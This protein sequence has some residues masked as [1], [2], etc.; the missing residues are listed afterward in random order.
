MTTTSSFRATVRAAG[1][2]LP[3]LVIGIRSRT[4]SGYLCRTQCDATSTDCLPW[5]RQDAFTGR[6]AYQPEQ[7]LWCRRSIA[8]GWLEGFL[9]AE[10]LAEGILDSTLGQGVWTRNR[11]GN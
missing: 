3:K 4:S 8:P 7:R 6:V 10:A 9:S 1:A 11:H 2:D 5:L